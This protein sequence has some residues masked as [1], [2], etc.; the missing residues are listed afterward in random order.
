[1]KQGQTCALTLSFHPACV[2]GA[3]HICQRSL[4]S[5]RTEKGHAYLNS[6][7]RPQIKRICL[8][9]TKTFTN[10]W[11]QNCVPSV[12]SSPLCLFQDRLQSHLNDMIHQEEQ[13]MEQVRLHT[14]TT[15]ITLH[16]FYIFPS[17][18]V[19]VVF[20]IQYCRA[21]ERCYC[22]T[23]LLL[24]SPQPIAFD[25]CHIFLHCLFTPKL[26]NCLRGKK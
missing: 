22:I 26:T 16:C 20:L 11:H 4:Q 23:C 6:S 24:D 17:L 15:L 3:G 7:H 18:W 19:N 25:Q 21:V 10:G 5:Q 2:D 14:H 12:L 13:E 8:H 1:M 9:A